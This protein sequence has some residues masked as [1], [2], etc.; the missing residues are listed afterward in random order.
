MDDLWNS[1][2]GFEGTKQLKIINDF[3]GSALLHAVL[4]QF[5]FKLE[6]G[7]LIISIMK[8]VIYTFHPVG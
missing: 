8:L 1:D 4:I 5:S 2:V 7:H 6:D 3:W